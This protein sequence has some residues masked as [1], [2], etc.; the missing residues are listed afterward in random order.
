MP[1]CLNS[2]RS[3]RERSCHHFSSERTSRKRTSMRTHRRLCLLTPR[4]RPRSMTHTSPPLAL[5][6]YT[7]GLITNMRLHSPLPELLP[8]SAAPPLPAPAPAALHPLRLR[9][10]P[11]PLSAEGP[12]P[13][14]RRRSPMPALAAP[15]P[16]A[17][18]VAAALC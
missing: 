2:T 8:P 13:T 3:Q 18:A 4:S 14:R 15:A 17:P 11:A 5:D 7:Y 1:I 16:L 6:R 10:V 12:P 9:E